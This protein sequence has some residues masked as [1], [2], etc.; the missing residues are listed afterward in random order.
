MEYMCSP[1]HYY[2]RQRQN[3]EF[4]LLD[5]SLHLL[6]VVM[7][8]LKLPGACTSL[9]PDANRLCSALMHE[10]HFQH[11]S[12]I[13]ACLSPL[14]H[15]AVHRNS[16]E[17]S[18]ASYAL[19]NHP[20][21]FPMAL[22][23]AMFDTMVQARKEIIVKSPQLTFFNRGLVG[24]EWMHGQPQ[25]QVDAPVTVLSQRKVKVVVRREKLLEEA[26]EL[27][28][29]HECCPFSLD[30]SF[31]G[32]PG[33]GLGPT[34]EFYNCLCLELE[35][36]SL[37]LWMHCDTESENHASYLYPNAVQTQKSLRYFTLIGRLIARLLLEGKTLSLNLHP[38]LFRRLICLG[39][40]SDATSLAAFSQIDS[41]VE[42]SLRKLLKMDEETLAEADLCFTLPG[43][44]SIELIPMGASIAVD[45]DN[46]GAYV[47]AVRQFYIFQCVELPVNKIMS[48]IATLFTPAHL[49]LFTPGELGLRLRGPDGCV[50]PTRQDL[51][52]DI[53]TNHGYTAN[54]KSIV[55]LINVVSG[56][57]A[58]RQR[59]FLRFISGSDRVPL[60]GLQ[61]GITVV[62]KDVNP[63]A[64]PSR[65]S[66][67]RTANDPN[68]LQREDSEVNEYQEHVD[69]SL[70]TV[71][72]CFH[73]LKLPEYSTQEILEAKLLVAIN[74]GQE[75]FML[76]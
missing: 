40:E 44:E 46:V 23:C 50:W 57:P 13:S 30:I 1:K 73:Y 7:R 61:Q 47:E 38:L 17:D 6:D 39:D 53:R 25:F 20:T 2:T 72:T 12:F 31:E 21:V 28:E 34:L 70:P 64:T 10:V 32:E 67:M 33:T 4:H 36:A 15:V 27:L 56:W 37:G 16:L 43:H 11:L 65:A 71:N 3:N 49:Q 58:D 14:C 24:G 9:G 19:W 41:N 69:E 5:E 54:S 35:Q 22:R 66:R 29:F 48:G 60:Q 74:D 42:N 8:V 26:M 76:S 55:F 63:D 68:Y 18:L 45:T 52:R 62:R 51:E 75:S 59:L